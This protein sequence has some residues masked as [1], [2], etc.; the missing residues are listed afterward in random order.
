M[1]DPA[2]DLIRLAL[3]TVADTAIVPLQDVL[4]LESE[5]RMN[6]P[7]RGLGNWSWRYHPDQLQPQ[8]AERLRGLVERY[9]RG[10][11]KPGP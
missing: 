5:A 3:S 2:W 6:T 4:S 10:P 7:G 9:N 1:S 8:I 11:A